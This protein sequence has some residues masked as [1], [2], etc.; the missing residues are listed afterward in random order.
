ME[1][2][3]DIRSYIDGEGL[4]LE[5]A[6]RRLTELGYGGSPDGRPVQAILRAHDYGVPQTRER[7]LIV[8]NRLGQTIAWP[9]SPTHKGCPITVWEAIS[10]LPVIAHECRLDEMPYEPRGALNDF[11]KLMREGCQNVVYNHQTRWHNQQDLHARVDA[12]RR[13]VY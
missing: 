4:L 6:L 7:L 10:D 11:Q 3:P 9:P 12:R 1:N 13:K 5:K 2:V 8:G